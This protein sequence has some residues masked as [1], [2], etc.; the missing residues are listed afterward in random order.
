MIETA[1][2]A[3]YDLTPLR[4]RQVTQQDFHDVDLIFGMDAANLVDLNA[5][6]PGSRASVAP[7]DPDRDV[8]DPYYTRDFEEALRIIEAAADRIL[9][10][11]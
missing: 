3:G 1:A 2:K 7:F 4:A 10:R 11:F 9:D 5:M 6:D 8:P